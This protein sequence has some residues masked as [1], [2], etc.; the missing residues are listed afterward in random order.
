MEADVINGNAVKVTP[1]KKELV[2]IEDEVSATS[3]VEN[4]YACVHMITNKST[5]SIV[6][7]L[8]F[9]LTVKA[10]PHECVIR[11]SQP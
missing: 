6:V 5:V 1:P 10:A 11:I 4:V 3:F 9:S 7:L 2:Y 8:D